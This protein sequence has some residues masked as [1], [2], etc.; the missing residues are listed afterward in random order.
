MTMAFP[1]HARAIGQC[2]TGRR[3]W[4]ERRGWDYSEFVFHGVDTER[5]KA[6]GDAMAI[7]VA[8]EAEREERDGR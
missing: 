3:Q 2:A 8:E 6:T 1:R 4:F 5:L 7:E